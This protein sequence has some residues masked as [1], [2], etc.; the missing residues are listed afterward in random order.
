MASLVAQVINKEI[1]KPYY[2]TKDGTEKHVR[3]GDIAILTRNRETA[4]VQKLVN[5]LIAHGI[6]VVSEV[7]QDICQTQEIQ[8]LINLLKLLYSFG[9]D[10]PLAST[11]K[12]AVGKFTEEDLAE[13]VLFYQDNFALQNG[14]KRG[15]FYNAYE[16]YL[17][18]AQTPLAKRLFEFDCY[19]KECRKLADFMGAH[20]I[21]NKIIL[22]SGFMAEIYASSHGDLKAKR[23]RKFLS[24][25]V[26]NGKKLS[27]SEFLSIIKEDKKSFAMSEIAEEDTVKIMTMHASK[28]LEFPVVIV[29]GIERNMRMEED[30]NLCFTDR[31][32]GFATKYFDK[33]ERTTKETLLRGVI[34]ECQREEDVKE[35]M[36][37]FYVATTRATY[38]M[39]LMVDGSLA[40]GVDCFVDAK[41]FKDLLPTTIEPTLH[42]ENDFSIINLQKGVKAVLFGEPSQQVTERIQSNLQFKYD[43]AED[44]V[45]PLK[46]SVTKELSANVE[47]NSLAHYLFDDEDTTDAEKGI[48][49]HKLLENLDFCYNLDLV[50]EGEKLVASG[51]FDKATLQKINLS[52]I[53]KLFDKGVFDR[54]VGK[55]LYRE[56]TFI[57]GIEANLIKDTASQEKVLIQGAVD[58]IAVGED[59]A[60]IIDYKYSSLMPISLKEKYSKQLQIY[61]RAFTIATG[62]KVKSTTLVNLFTGDVVEV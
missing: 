56:K 36:R 28:G 27:V 37:L 10:I 30:K 40:N 18:N 33:K 52:K 60:E 20:D 35:E 26:R 46:S 8:T 16:F 32:F 19:F 51:V 7:A 43:Y 42:D 22:D 24:E 12:S 57:A 45:L 6:P 48:I 47:Q 54:V 17:Q 4:Y 29:C 55:K 39:H 14:Q 1:G 13:I 25:S 21:L 23:V 31:R 34:K 50:K 49:A 11:L 38:S 53:Q 59:G 9:G 58:L 62:I 44:S 2:D 41:S 61:A 3:Y 15:S 5:G